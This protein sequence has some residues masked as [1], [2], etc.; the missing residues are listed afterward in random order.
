MAS[1]KSPQEGRCLVNRQQVER[2]CMK[3]ST[4]PLLICCLIASTGCVLASLDY[5]TVELNYIPAWGTRSFDSANGFGF[6]VDTIGPESPWA[7]ES[8][9]FLQN[10]LSIALMVCEPSSGARM[11][12]GQVTIGFQVP[13]PLLQKRRERFVFMPWYF[14][15]EAGMYFVLESDA[16]HNPGMVVS[17]EMSLFWLNL[18]EKKGDHRLPFANDFYL[19][20]GVQWMLWGSVEGTLY[21]VGLMYFF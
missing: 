8:V 7:E 6:E 16:G 9:S 20:F 17:L 19:N 21:K 12:L 2:A 18:P 13:T 1:R 11:T 10:S 14:D 15:V 3:T 4:K 5:A